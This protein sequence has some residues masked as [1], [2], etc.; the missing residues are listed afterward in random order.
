VFEYL[1]GLNLP[2]FGLHSWVSSIRDRVSVHPDYCG[3]E[4]VSDGAALAD[5]EYA[6]YEGKLTEFLIKKGHLEQG[7][8]AHERPRYHLEVKATTSA[9]WQ[10]PF[11]LSK[12]QE[13]HVKI[14]TPKL[15]ITDSMK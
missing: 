9:N 15:D 7:L 10:E 4:K 2:G 14:P 12:A 6:D 1:N 5:I 8:W 13:F 11:Y 3:I